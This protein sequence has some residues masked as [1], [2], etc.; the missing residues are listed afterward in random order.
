MPEGR[1]V[2][3]EAAPGAAEELGY[4]V[5]VK[6]LSRGLA[7]KADAGAVRLG[8]DDAGA[9]AEAVAD[10]SRA[11]SQTVPEALSDTFLVER[12]VEESIAELLIGIH[13]DRQFGL[14]MVLASGGTLVELLRDSRTL[15][16]PT[17]RESVSQAIAELRLSR[18]LNGFRGRPA[19]DREA[20]VDAVMAVA[21]F[22]TAHCD[23]LEEVEVN[24]L[25]VLPRG[26]AAVDVLLRMA[27]SG[28][29]ADV[30]VAG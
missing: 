6:M 4:P 26:V 5:A 29:K 27:P 22:A 28:D 25:I 23:V 7:H 1:L 10:I 9:V 12:M 16:L 19:G 3:A 2:A 17:D 18:L 8:L 13:R 21:E 14:V 11:V 24:P 30:A 15:L 20:A